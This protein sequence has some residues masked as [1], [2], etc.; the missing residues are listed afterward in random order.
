MMGKVFHLRE[1]CRVRASD[2][3]RV[4]IWVDGLIVDWVVVS[5][6]GN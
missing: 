5:V 2:R 3:D 6:A 4:M 1:R